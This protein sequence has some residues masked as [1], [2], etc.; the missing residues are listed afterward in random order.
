M[1]RQIAL[2]KFLMEYGDNFSI[3]EIMFIK[4]ALKFYGEDNIDEVNWKRDIINIAVGYAYFLKEYKE[5]D[6]I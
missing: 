1:E 5:D 2:A 4:K 6:I 3:S